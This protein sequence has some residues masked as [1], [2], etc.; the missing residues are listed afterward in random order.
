MRRH[1]RPSELARRFAPLMRPDVPAP[2][3]RDAVDHRWYSYAQSMEGLILSA[4]TPGWVLGATRPVDL[5]AALDDAVPDVVLLNDLRAANP[6][7]SLTLLADGGHD[8]PLRRTLHCIEL[9][10]SRLDK[11]LRRESQGM[12]TS[13]EPL[14]SP[15][16]HSAET[17][18]RELDL[19]TPT[20][21]TVGPRRRRSPS[22]ISTHHPP[23]PWPPG[24]RCLYLCRFR[25]TRW[26]GPDGVL[27]CH[28]AGTRRLGD[29]GGEQQGCQGHQGRDRRREQ[30]WRLSERWPRAGTSWAS[31]FLRQTIERSDNRPP[32][33]GVD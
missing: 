20:S 16:A 23:G 32:G 26:C 1:V 31:G 17:P 7:V 27:E 11:R 9:I 22:P 25:R 5:V 6:L 29:E 2:V 13:G 33:E 10:Q 18:A 3:A 30:P 21:A 14:A 8:L 24:H 4:E 15:P 12:P 28:A 19:P